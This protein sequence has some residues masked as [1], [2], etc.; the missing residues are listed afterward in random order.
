V[1]VTRTSARD[2][3]AGHTDSTHPTTPSCERTT[4]LCSETPMVYSR[5]TMQAGLGG[6]SVASAAL[7]PC[8][9]LVSGVRGRAP[10]SPL[11]PA[12]PPN[13]PV[14]AGSDNPVIPDSTLSERTKEGRGRCSVPAGSS[15]G[16]LAER[17]PSHPGVQGGCK[18]PP[19]VSLLLNVSTSIGP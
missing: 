3:A 14:L 9:V 12:G 5:D 4:P 16:W 8:P 1:S 11:S 7:S 13:D 2:T 19:R 18:K 17:Q 10:T 15:P 6:A